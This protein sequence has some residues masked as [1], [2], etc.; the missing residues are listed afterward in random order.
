MPITMFFIVKN[1][2]QPY[3]TDN[4][5]NKACAGFEVLTAVVMTVALHAAHE[6]N[7]PP[8]RRITYRLHGAISRKKATFI[9]KPV[10]HKAMYRRNCSAILMSVASVTLR[11][12]IPGEKDRPSRYSLDRR[13]HGLQEPV[14]MLWSRENSLVP[15]WNR[16]PAIQTVASRYRDWA[17]VRVLHLFVSII[18]TFSG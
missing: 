9:I 17:A 3:F 18:D 12:V 6:P 7:V 13:L 16:T 5:R 8:K 11:S 1:H 4:P 10:S 14:W 15:L 2:W